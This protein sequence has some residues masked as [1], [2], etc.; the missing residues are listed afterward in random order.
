MAGRPP[1]RSVNPDEAVAHG[2]ALYAD[3]IVQRRGGTQ[4]RFSITNINSHS[5][6]IVGIDPVTRQRRNQIL[7]AKNTPLPQT[8]TRVFRTMQV[9]QPLVTIRVVEGESERPEACSQVGVLTIRD[10]PKDLPE[11]WPVQVSYSYQENGQLQVAAKLQGHPSIVTTYF[12]REN[13]LEDADLKTWTEFVSQ[14]WQAKKSS[15]L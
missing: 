10:L 7:I 11:G 14:R 12:L 6:G 13:S 3:L 9:G 1:D 4:P 15:E 5:L 8:V 2:A